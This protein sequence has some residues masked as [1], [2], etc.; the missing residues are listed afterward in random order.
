[1]LCRGERR[2]RRV[3]EFGHRGTD[4]HEP[5][6]ALKRSHSDLREVSSVT[7]SPPSPVILK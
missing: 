2:G 1:P 6:C 5:F 4:I 3:N 7:P